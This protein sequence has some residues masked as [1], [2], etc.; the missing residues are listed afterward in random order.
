MY[1]TSLNQKQKSYSI[2]ARPQNV[3]LQLIY[4]VCVYLRVRKEEFE[5]RVFFIFIKR[6]PRKV[7]FVNEPGRW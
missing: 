1:Q 7:I 3:K 2:V 5:I 6:Y 4:S